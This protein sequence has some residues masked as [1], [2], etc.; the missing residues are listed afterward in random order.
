MTDAELG[1]DK[2]ERLSEMS[3]RE[4]AK[5]EMVA[6]LR[7]LT[8]RHRLQLA[9]IAYADSLTKMDRIPR[10]RKDR[11]T[12]PGQ[13]A[14]A[15]AQYEGAKEKLEQAALV[16]GNALVETAPNPNLEEHENP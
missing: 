2:P 5:R 12:L 3:F 10:S 1:A 11:D 14:E 15:M 7:N 6:L 9:A 8:P 4:R 13:F 16:F